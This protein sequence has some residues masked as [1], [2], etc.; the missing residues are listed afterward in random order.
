MGVHTSGSSAH[1]ARCSEPEPASWTTS[2]TPTGNL[3]RTVVIGNQPP[4]GSIDPVGDAG[5]GSIAFAGWALDPDM[6]SSTNVHVYVDGQ[7]ILALTAA[8]PRP[9]VAAAF[10][11]GP[12][13]GFDATVPTTTGT[14]NVCLYAIDGNGGTNTLLGCRTVTTS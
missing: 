11:R 2:I 3:L 9:D 5:S 7:G 13:H 12:N 4:I 1:P 6:T 10:G 8:N 14:H